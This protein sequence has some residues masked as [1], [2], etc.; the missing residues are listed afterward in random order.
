MSEAVEVLALDP[1]TKTGVSYG[2]VGGTPKLWTENFGS[3]D[4]QCEDVYERAT[5]WLANFLVTHKPSMFAIEQVVPPSAARGHTNHNTTMITVGLYGVFVGLI[6]CKRIEC[7]PVK[8]AT[9]RKH[10]L[11]KGNYNTVDAKR[12][13]LKRCRLLNWEP[14]DHNSAEAGGI[15]DWACQSLRSPSLL[16]MKW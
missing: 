5:Y 9:W 16:E 8:I 3:E 4:S 15:W 7:K 11:G 10:F 1:A 12:A 6:R 14:T 2:P 13:A